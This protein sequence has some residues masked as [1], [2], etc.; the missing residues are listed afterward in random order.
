MRWFLPNMRKRGFISQQ[1]ET[2]RLRMILMVAFSDLG[3]I[4]RFFPAF[5]AIFYLIRSMCKI[6][7]L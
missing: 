4:F 1:A 2:D 5:L 6:V 3:F 7:M